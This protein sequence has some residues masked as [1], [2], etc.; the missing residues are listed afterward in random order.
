MEENKFLSFGAVTIQVHPGYSVDIQFG[1]NL[2]RAALRLDRM[3]FVET[4]RRPI[5]VAEHKYLV[6]AKLP[7]V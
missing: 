4:R 5:Y 1:P 7:L 6:A 3:R 2:L